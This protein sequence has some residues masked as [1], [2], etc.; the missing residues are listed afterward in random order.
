MDAK[1]RTRRSSILLIFVSVVFE[2][3][4]RYAHGIL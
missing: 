1:A 2:I 4:L 3:C